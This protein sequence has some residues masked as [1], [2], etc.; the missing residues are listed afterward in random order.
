MK[1]ARWSAAHE[2]ERPAILYA[3][4]SRAADELGD[5]MDPAAYA[6][7]EAR[8]WTH[9][10]A[11]A[12]LEV[13]AFVDGEEVLALFETMRAECRIRVEG[14][15][16]RG[17]ARCLGSGF[18]PPQHRLVGY[19]RKL[20][21]MVVNQHIAEGVTMMWGLSETVTRVY[22]ETRST[23]PGEIIVR[24]W[25]ASP[26]DASSDAYI[27]DL[28]GWT[29]PPLIGDW[30]VVVSPNM[31]TWRIDRV[32]A[33]FP[34]DAARPIGARIGES[35]AVWARAGEDN[36]LEL[37]HLRADAETAPQLVALAQAEAA[38]R[39]LSTVVAWENPVNRAWLPEGEQSLF[40]DVLL[41]RLSDDQ[42]GATGWTTYEMAHNL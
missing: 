25:P 27:T 4:D 1:L 13:W 20:S 31:L 16:R 17:S 7:M 32:A 12:G 9:P 14:G 35:W 38:A 22:S 23:N 18:V 2:P 8:M 28:D 19:G 26:A 40:E 41:L 37:L 3:H 29:E 36:A 10:A 39:G 11:R 34:A 5:G 21:G 15:I 42:L 24:S 33:K 30:D 6:A